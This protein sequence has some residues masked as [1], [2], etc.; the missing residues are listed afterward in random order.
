[1]TSPDIPRSLPKGQAE[2]LSNVVNRMAAGSHRGITRWARP[3]QRQTAPP[4]PAPGDSI[5]GSITYATSASSPVHLGDAIDLTD[6]FDEYGDTSC[7][8]L[9][10]GE[11]TVTVDGVYSFE[12]GFGG[13]YLTPFG[14]VGDTGFLAIDGQRA[15]GI[16]AADGGLSIVAHEGPLLYTASTVDLASSAITG[17]EDGTGSVYIRMVRWA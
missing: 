7:F 9:D 10:T 13:P 2:R 6:S 14:T 4:R 5:L 12:A 1:M 3:V 15:Y 16:A 17:A 11:A 8:A